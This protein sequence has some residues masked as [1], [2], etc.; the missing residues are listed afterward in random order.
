[1]RELQHEIQIHST[2]EFK[3]LLRRLLRTT[4]LI[5]YG[6]RLD[7]LATQQQLHL[8]KRDRTELKRMLK[9]MFNP[10]FGSVF[11]TSHHR[12]EF[13]DS[14]SRYADLYTSNVNNMLN[15]QLTHTLS[16]TRDERAS[17]MTAESLN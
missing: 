10:S 4:A 14:V 5:D 9:V 2:P 13:F 16:V 12:T 8:L 3:M 6:Q 17:F 1:V 15:Y 11:R 7:D